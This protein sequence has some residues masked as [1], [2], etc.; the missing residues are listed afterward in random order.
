[1]TEF[2]LKNFSGDFDHSIGILNSPGKCL[3]GFRFLSSF[4]FF[5]WTGKLPNKIEGGESNQR[6]RRLP[7]NP[8]TRGEAGTGAGEK[9]AEEGREED[10]EKEWCVQVTLVRLIMTMAV[11]VLMA[12]LN[13]GKH[14]FGFHLYVV[15]ES[16][17]M[18]WLLGFWSITVSVW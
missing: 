3:S 6:R 11:V 10:E 12:I 16:E 2:E 5:L 1:M 7:C 14:I 9:R 8:P 17:T 4:H 15:D 18:K 13:N